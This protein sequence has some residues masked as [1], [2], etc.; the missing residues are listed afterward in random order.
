MEGCPELGFPNMS[1]HPRSRWRLRTVIERLIA[2]LIA[3]V[4]CQTWVI[5]GIPVA[6]Q[7]SGGSMAET[8]LGEHF[9]LKCPDCGSPF[10]CDAGASRA[11]ALATCPNCGYQ[12]VPLDDQRP[13]PGERV[14]IDRSSFCLRSPQRWQVAALYQPEQGKAIAVK[15]IVGLPEETIRIHDGDVYVDGQVQRKNLLEQ[16]AV[17]ILV[18][19]A[20]YQARLDPAPPPRWRGEDKEGQWNW[21]G[22]RCVH[23]TSSDR[24]WIDWL[25]YSHGR[26]GADAGTILPG[27]I[28]DLCPYNR[29]RPRRE[30]DVHPVADVALSVRVVEASGP[31]LL[32]LRAT[33]GR[34]VFQTMLS[35]QAGKYMV[36]Q[37]GKPMPA[38]AG[39][40]PGPL[41]GTL[42]E[43]SLFDQQFLLAM[44][45]RTVVARAYDRPDGS[46]VPLA[47]PVAI[48]V[49][50]LGT[51]LQDLRVYRDV[52][53]TQAV[54]GRSTVDFEK[55][56]HLG[57]G[58]YFVL[59]D[60][61][62]ISEDSR[63]W[64]TG[65][66][67]SAGALIGRPWIVVY[68]ASH[69]RIGPWQFQVPEAGRIRY[70]R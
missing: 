18:H 68:P 16:R 5:Q 8:L 55:G 64:A 50:E 36:L 53:Y 54:A 32:W 21:S 42:L 30:E 11:K 59:G 2:L 45:G 6:C 29:G 69:A 46:H 20:D 31:G 33:D 67:V 35:P 19:D 52:Y 15:R 65:P 10:V 28:T 56:F 37:N 14:W 60:N 58:E 49:Q 1:A 34:E 63:V 9:A 26:R 61:S 43:M 62:P 24:D 12:D 23:P 38:G 22:V 17:R 47:E 3:L 4:A 44:N 13:L 66:G 27:P 41:K 48:G 70:I 7:V 25:V 40:L 51:M 39:K 57:Q